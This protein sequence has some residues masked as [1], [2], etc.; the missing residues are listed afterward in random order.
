MTRST[1]PRTAA[2]VLFA[3]AAS[4]FPTKAGATGHLDC[5]LVVAG[6]SVDPGTLVS[7]LP[8]SAPLELRGHCVAYIS[9]APSQSMHALGASDFTLA[10]A[11]CT[12]QRPPPH[13]L[14][15]RTDLTPTTIQFDEVAPTA[16]ARPDTDRT[17]RSREPLAPGRY[18]LAWGD[19]AELA[20][21]V[22]PAPTLP[23][24]PEA[25]PEV[26]SSNTQQ[27]QTDTGRVYLPQPPPESAARAPARDDWEDRQGI[28]WEAAV[29]PW[30]SFATRTERRGFDR[31]LGGN[32]WVGLHYVMKPLHSE[33]HEKSGDLLPTVESMRWC[34]PVLLCGGIGLFFAPASALAGNE[35]GLDA[36]V[37]WGPDFTR[38]GV[39]P[40]ARYAHGAVRTAALSGYL[41][42]EVTVDWRRDRG[43][44]LALVWSLY[45]VDLRFG[46]SASLSLNAL[47]MGLVIGADSGTYT[48]LGPELAF[49]YAP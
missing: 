10:A 44:G 6:A 19:Y 30:A 40:F 24:C 11:T 46:S 21:E 2:A 34:I 9:V 20:I 27:N 38:A 4:V 29:G 37:A 26:A 7:R 49:L 8:A 45:P 25:P 31:A 41:L 1:T 17:Y 32:A 13:G 16:D 15:N 14:R 23:A 3:C 18:L 42:P 43:T 33:P 5:S 36:H 35:L 48:E 12:P 47:R 22:A 28:A 39:R